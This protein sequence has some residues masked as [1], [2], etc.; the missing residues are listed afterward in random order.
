[1]DLTIRQE[2]RAGIPLLEIWAAGQEHLP[3]VVVQ[4]GYLGRKEFIL[5]Q[6]YFLAANGFFTVVPDAWQHGDNRPSAVPD[7]FASIRESAGALPG[8][9][10]DYAGDARADTDRCGFVGYSMGGMIGFYSLT[11]PPCPFTAVCP[12]IGTPDWASVLDAPDAQ[13]LFAQLHADASL[14]WAALRLAAAA[15]SPLNRPFAPVPLLIQNGAQDSLIPVEAVRR[16]VARIR[17][18][19][20]RPDDLNL[21][22]YANQGH[23]DTIEMNQRVVA[24]LK[25]YLIRPEQPGREA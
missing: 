6:A 2:T 10:A 22:V 13:A 14:D 20:A 7:L 11:L 19:Y 3:L 15:G 9:V 4:H 25:H 17:P 12:L 16:F 5:P 18:Q 24:W 8:L 21:I 23:A 1:M